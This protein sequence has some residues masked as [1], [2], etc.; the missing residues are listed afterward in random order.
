MTLETG[1]M[2]NF[3][4]LNFTPNKKDKNYFLIAMIFHNLT[5]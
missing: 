4:L 5:V 1:V 3:Q 2:L